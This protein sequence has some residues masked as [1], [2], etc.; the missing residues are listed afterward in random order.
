MLFRSQSG[1]WDKREVMNGGWNDVRKY[2]NEV[3]KQR[4]IWEGEARVRFVRG[5]CGRSYV[6]K[7][8]HMSMLDVK[9]LLCE[10]V[11]RH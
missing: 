10:D 9:I 8:E 6:V 4:G 11:L 1:K 2:R 3:L 7:C 5:R